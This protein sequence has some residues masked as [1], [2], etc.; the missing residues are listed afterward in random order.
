MKKTWNYLSYIGVQNKNKSLETRTQ[1]LVNQM[2]AILFVA[3]LLLSIITTIR[4]I[5]GANVFNLGAYRLYFLL[6]V[7]ILIFILSKYSY[8]SLNKILLIF[9]PIIIIILIP[10]LWG[11]VEEESFFYYSIAIIGFSL[12]PQLFFIPQRETFLYWFSLGVFF[13]FLLFYYDFI[14]FFSPQEF[15]IITLIQQFIIFYI[16]VPIIVFIFIHAAIYYLRSLNLKFENQIIEYNEELNSTLEEL[17]TTQQH[18]VQSEKMA[19]L[20]TLTAG[21]AHEIN[22]PLNFIN[23]GI[24]ILSDSKISNDKCLSTEQ[25]ELFN[26]S[27]EMIITGF[28]RTSSIVKSL[29]SFS[30]SETPTLVNVDINQMIDDTILFLNS[31]SSADILINKNYKIKEKITVFKDQIHQVIINIIDNAIFAVSQNKGQKIINIITKVENNNTV[32]IIENNGAQ[33]NDTDISQIFDPFFTT[34]EPGKGIGLGLSIS[35]NLITQHNGKIL[36]ENT[37]LGVAFK[38]E[39]PILSTQSS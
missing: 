38:I 36:V 7:N 30:Y 6:M 21:V 31:N 25:K 22:N 10:T 33:I 12:L 15:K 16:S 13:S 3:I 4:I 24:E 29:M 32:I 9:A 18:L 14:V 23:G 2:N 20:G 17:K 8:F 19:S 37:P 39:I 28:E 1:I 5:N 26:S 27:L 35:Y 11:F 34:K